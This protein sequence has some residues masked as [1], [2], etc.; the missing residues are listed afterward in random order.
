MNAIKK[1]SE[2]FSKL[3]YSR[4]GLLEQYTFAD[5]LSAAGTTRSVELAAFT[6]TPPSYRTAAFGVIKARSENVNEQLQ[7]C[8][9]LGAP[10]I[11]V[12]RGSQVELWQ[13]RSTEAPRRIATSGVD[14][15]ANLFAT[16][17]EF[18][19][20]LAVHRAKAILTPGPRQLDFIDLGLMVAI[21]GEVHEK[22][23][24]LL[25][26][27]LAATNDV[28]GRPAM[29]ARTLFQATF[30]F[31]AAKILSDRGHNASASW[32]DGDVE[33]VLR[34]IESYY[35]LESV[36]LGKAKDR[37]LLAGV[38]TRLREGISFRN[39][40]AD[41]LAFV[42]E[43]TFVTAEVRT[44]LGTHSTPRQMAEH[45]VRGLNLWKNP[46][47]I[48][49][50]E[51]FTGAGVLLVA[52]LRQLRSALPLDWSDQKRHTFLTK[53]I[54]G[55]EL[56]AFACEVAKLSLIL[57]DYPNHNGWDI[58]QTDL[59]DGD[60]LA[61]RIDSS[62]F[63]VCNPPF[64]DFA[65]EDRGSTVSQ[66][67]VSKPV[68]VLLAVLD[69]KPAGI[70]FVLPPT[71]PVERR[72]ADVRAR[73]E[74]DFNYVEIV[75]I[76]DDIFQASRTG[77]SLLIARDRRAS[78]DKKIELVS[79]EV[80]L[81]DR[82][83]FLKA[84]VLT[85]TRKLE[86]WTHLP[87]RGELWVPELND[88]WLALEGNTRLGDV[89]D[90]HRGI[91][92]TIDQSAAVSN[93][94][95]RGFKRGLHSSKNRMQFVDQP[96]QYLDC[97][98]EHSRGGALALP[99]H[100]DKIVLNAARLSRYQWRL[101]ASLDTKGLVC[102]QQ[103][104]GVWPKAPME[105]SQLLELCAILNGPIANAYS[106]V[107]TSQGARFRIATLDQI[108]L[109]LN[110]RPEVAGLVESY[111]ELA[112]E[113]EVL[114]NVSEKLQPLLV[115]IDA[116]VLQSYGLSTRLERDLLEYFEG[117]RRP[118][119][120]PWS[121][122]ADLASTQGLRLSEIRAGF[123]KRLSGNWISGVFRPLPESEAADLREYLS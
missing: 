105:R 68:A 102:S 60:Q 6:Q 59:F 100:D 123:D 7:E 110:V 63:V 44:K 72:Y 55:D 45:V 27:T 114:S 42:Y 52:A 106:A 112:Q 111:L 120:H 26:E 48:K 41:D 58:K 67:N 122:W 93:R 70:G 65:V 108:P 109:P 75:E 50:Y 69:A 9:A 11:F 20:P 57:A 4:D 35:G 33:T 19:S 47:D 56:D 46:E 92:W 94:P 76:P 28:R 79:S 87:P 22:L 54:K 16:H 101:A 40:S 95:L 104:L 2:N 117:A 17:K 74:E 24:T 118:V 10:A 98:E 34:G 85:R 83:P 38:W 61:K 18:W 99:W 62:T 119:V 43:N 29:D 1:L 3:G 90:M 77:A 84:G 5:V 30:R 36:Q 103:F 12:V 31:L 115:A 25:R 96:I 64:E 49:V 53:R 23:D 97:S 66:M 73:L 89:V 37:A 71:F 91:E 113:P 13:V 80:S 51:P 107:F 116:A 88:L 81:R 8:R 82:L 86:R 39:I 121:G 78:S 14:D 21:E 32:R 15:L